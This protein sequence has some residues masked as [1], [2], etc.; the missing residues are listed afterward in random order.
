MLMYRFYGPLFVELGPQLGLLYKATDE[1]TQDVFDKND[2]LFINNIR[3]EYRRIDAGLTGGL[4]YKFQKG[5]GMKI[6][7]RYYL[8]LT[9]ILKENPGDPQKNRSLYLYAS[10]P[11][12]AGK[13]KAKREAEAKE[14]Q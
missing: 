10:I 2:L 11:I 6:G 1:F 9:E 13:A 7:V 14:S 4:G 5:P 8:G 12:G 3:D